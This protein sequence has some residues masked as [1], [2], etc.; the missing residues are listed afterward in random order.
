ML[1]L[2]LGHF[3]KFQISEDFQFTQRNQIR[4]EYKQNS[5]YDKMKL[6]FLYIFQGFSFLVFSDRDW[7]FALSRMTPQ[8]KK[9]LCALKYCTVGTELL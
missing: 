3:K 1:I 8:K 9:N 4:E 7:N 2:E 6:F 5:Y